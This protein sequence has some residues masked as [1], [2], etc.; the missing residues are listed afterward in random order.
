MSSKSVEDISTR[1]MINI[2]KEIRMKKLKINFKIYFI[3]SL[4]AVSSH[5]L[6]FSQAVYIKNYSDFTAFPYNTTAYKQDGAFVGCG[7]TTGAMIFAYFDHVNGSNLLKD[8]LTGTN[9]GLNTAWAL[10]GSSYMKTGADGFGSVYDIKPGLENYAADRGYTVKA[11]IHVSPTYSSSSTSW[12]SYGSYGEAWLN[13]GTFWHTDGTNWWID[14]DDFC[15][16]IAPKLSAGIAVFLTIDTDLNGSGDHWVPL[17]GYNKSTGQYAF[18]DT[19]STTLKWADIHYCGAPGAKKDNAI[20]FLRTVEYQGS[21]SQPSPTELIAL[22]GY[23]GAVPLVWNKPSV[24]AMAKTSLSGAS[25]LLLN[26][27]EN[28][29]TAFQQDSDIPV[30]LEMSPDA[31]RKFNGALLKA[32]D[33]EEQTDLAL[34]AVQGYNIYRTTASG[35][36]LGKIAS[37]VQN[38]HD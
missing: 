17:V 14:A 7:P 35:G 11:L 24:T 18:Y 8:P 2:I 1:E 15:D 6:V 25:N 5:Q 19:Y 30:L 32:N 10:H 21:S 9:E 36:V 33:I 27:F 16:F 22:S 31:M 28:Q 26:S 4:L 38:H 23:N 12:D 20:S 34:T 37:N 13:D 3:M 29:T